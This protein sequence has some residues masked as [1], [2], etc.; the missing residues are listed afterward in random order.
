MNTYQA[1]RFNVFVKGGE[2]AGVLL[3]IGEWNNVKREM[4]DDESTIVY[5]I[6]SE[7][8]DLTQKQANRFL[9]DFKD[10]NTWGWAYWNWNLI[11][12]P[13]PNVN[14]ITVTKDRDIFPTKYYDILKRA[15]TTS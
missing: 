3:Y 4:V 5:Q 15:T 11:P 13:V 7:R 8:N 9:E 10:A 14:L 2:L 12:H 6:N 1:D